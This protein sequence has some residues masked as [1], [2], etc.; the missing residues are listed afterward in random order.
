MY[1]S[2]GNYSA[3]AR[4]RK[5]KGVDQK[6]AYL[7]GAGLG[8]LSAA[9][10]L[11]RDGQ[12]DGK[13]I[14]IIEA[15]KL[16]GGAL[17][18][19]KDE[20]RGF[21]VR[22]DRELEDHMEC[23]WDVCRSIPSLEIEGA[24]VLDAYFWVNKDDPN[25]HL[26]RTT[27][28][29]GKS[30]PTEGKLTISPT[31]Q[32]EMLRLFITPDEDLADKRISDVLG[33]EFLESNFWM[34]W[35]NMFGFVPHHGALEMKLYLNRFVHLIHGMTN[36]S[37][38]TYSRYNQYES[39]ALPMATWLKEKGVNFQVDTRVT[40]V[41]F[42]FTAGRKVARRIE[43]L[44]GGQRGGVDLTES[45]LVFITNGS[46]VENS[47]WG[48][49]HTAAT[50]DPEIHEGGIWAMWR[51]IAKQDPSFGRPDK[52]CTHTDE[53][54]WMTASLTTLDVEVA[55][56]M[57][58]I[59]QRD[60]LAWHQHPGRIG[61]GGGTI[62]RDSAWA[63][64]WTLERQ[65]HFKEQPKGTGLVW[66]VGLKP[67]EPGNFVKKPMWKCTGEEVAREWLYHLGVPI[68]KIPELA[69]K[70]TNC[71]PCALPF[72]VAFFLPRRAGDRPNVVPK[73][74]VNAAFIGQFAETPRDTI[75]TVEYSVRTAM[76]A[77]YTLL[78]IERGVPEV[79][80]SMYDM[81]ALLK[82]TAVMRDGEKV[83][84]PD[85][86]L[87]QVKGTDIE[88]LLLQYGVIA[89]P[90]VQ[91]TPSPDRQVRLPPQGPSVPERQRP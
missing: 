1:Y 73:N 16:P 86:I 61:S 42:D 8:S 77:V 89:E 51:N 34:Y 87:D 60:P 38:I 7:I 56:Y 80:G 68:E 58:K 83:E 50:F 30:F 71:N 74:V 70:S 66:M 63:L 35:R 13:R 75:F 12:M 47:S 32:A 64:T 44:R 81:R 2:A 37:T 33:Q 31:A 15:S 41:E 79:W 65:P 72:I 55:R 59:I 19:I 67:N 85:V 23:L 82:A 36:L 20:H 9:I 21:L 88:K 91:S 84:L 3:F 22:G 18:G 90:K 78:D 49:H 46:L 10:L 26:H 52:F 29:R 40:N 6:S 48:D 39:F 11:I 76:E 14:T 45:D 28:D 25:V 5:P 57:E 43:W 17:D 69:A 54:S 4:P 24:S 62:V 27:Q 53:S